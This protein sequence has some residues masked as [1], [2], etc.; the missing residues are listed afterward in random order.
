MTTNE[1][2]RTGGGSVAHRALLQIQ[3]H[4]IIAGLV[5]YAAA[6]TIFAVCV[7]GADVD[8]SYIF[9]QYA[10]N[11]ADT[12]LLA[13]NPAEP[14]YGITSILWT[15]LLA[16]GQLLFRN[17]IFAAK[18]W[19]IVLGAG[20]AVLWCKW[21]SDRFGARFS[22]TAVVWAALLPTI[23][24]GRMICGMEIPAVAF[25]TGLLLV[26]ASSGIGHRF[27]WEG[28]LGGL[29]IL[30]RPELAVI[31]AGL[32]VYR[33]LKREYLAA[34]GA[35]AVAMIVA[36]PWV[37]W[38]YSQTGAL[39]P[40]T[41]YGKLAVF[42]PESIGPTVAGFADAGIG[43]RIGW[44]VKALFLFPGAALSHVAILLLATAAIIFPVVR[45]MASPR[46]GV[47][48]LFL[49]A[50][51]I[52][53][54]FMLYGLYFPLLQLRYFVWLVPGLTAAVV[55]SGQDL[56]PG[57]W[58]RR[59]I[60]AITISCLVL[61][62]PGVKHRMN[63]NTVQQIRRSVAVAIEA[64]TPSDARIALEP[65][66]E[67][68][69][70]ADRYIVD[71]GGLISASVHPWIVNGYQDTA[72]IW[73]CLVAESADYLVTYANDSFLGRLPAAYPDR[74]ILTMLVPPENPK[75]G[76]YLIIK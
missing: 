49:P 11:W 63:A 15:G 8:D 73:D 69:F 47:G 31:P 37:M 44:A 71:M 46:K 38:L 70:Y 41:R 4:S 57:K 34:V 30:V 39:L 50:V 16:I 53:F 22:L 25:F 23:D 56:L 64:G 74:F 66:G 5:I 12:G 13:F 18:F 19:G 62:T 9:F 54:L 45:S 35:A 59:V 76:T 24:A 20:G 14:S 7:D 72:R 51:I 3:S 65:I 68:G 26:T 29:V 2:H 75:Y 28:L 33:L 6:A 55:L 17:V 36:A 52:V 1:I 40:P 21:L 32:F 61:F 10:R 67:I 27:L 58:R 42:L 48:A 60:W 43:Q